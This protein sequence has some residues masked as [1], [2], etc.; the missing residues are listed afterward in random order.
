MNLEMNLGKLAG[1]P[2]SEPGVN[3]KID[4]VRAKPQVSGSLE[5]RFRFTIH[6]Q[7]QSLGSGSLIRFRFCVHIQFTARVQIQCSSSVSSPA[8]NSW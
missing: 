6:V 8:E 5:P 4:P 7:V 3:L 1:E 2:A